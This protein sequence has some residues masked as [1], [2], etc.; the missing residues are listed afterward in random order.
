MNSS[1]SHSGTHIETVAHGMKPRWWSELT[2]CRLK[3]RF[4]VGHCGRR[5]H[6]GPLDRHA[7]AQFPPELT[8]L[9]V[10]ERKARVHLRIL[11]WVGT[12]S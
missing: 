9:D 11:S 6:R 4:D 1:A 5:R 12:T 7:R 8:R 10:R 3:P 2:A